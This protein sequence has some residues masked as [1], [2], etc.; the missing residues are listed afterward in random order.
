[1]SPWP[2]WLGLAAACRA[3]LFC[4]VVQSPAGRAL[5][6]GAGVAAAL[7]GLVMGW[8]WQWPAHHEERTAAEQRLAQTRTLLEGVRHQ[9]APPA[10][11]PGLGAS[12]Q[13]LA[14]PGLWPWHR[15]ALSAG[16]VVERGQAMPKESSAIPAPVRL[17]LRGRYHQHGAWVA[18]MASEL[19]APRLHSHVLQADDAGVHVAEVLLEPW[20]DIE[21]GPALIAARA[22]R[23]ANDLDPMAEPVR[24][25]SALALA[26][27]PELGAREPPA[28]EAAALDELTLTGTLYRQ[29]QWVA[30]L[31]WQHRVYTV[32]AGDGL[33]GQAWRV[34]RVEEDGLWL[35]GALR[36]DSGR[37]QPREQ[38]WRV[39]GRP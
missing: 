13:G 8:A 32:R 6:L 7:V 39:G 4:Q 28:M 23:P 24:A 15:L 14:D 19:A 36:D 21:R 27:A 37:W 34:Q 35:Q 17:R 12:A 2:G 30:L 33:S 31:S 5:P 26:A 1:M 10:L 3:W 22:Y 29:G 25:D 16:L 9:T 20:P 18:L 38:H 11:A